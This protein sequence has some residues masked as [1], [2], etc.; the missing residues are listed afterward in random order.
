MQ[1]YPRNW[2]GLELAPR[3]PFNADSS[4]VKHMLQIIK[5]CSHSLTNLELDDCVSILKSD[6]LGPFITNARNLTAI[7]LTM[8]LGY[9]QRAFLN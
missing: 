4:C 1:T 3:V 9:F 5:L 7:G 2:S 8:G 6:N